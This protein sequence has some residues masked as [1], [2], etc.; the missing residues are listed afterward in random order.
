MSKTILQ[1]AAAMAGALATLPLAACGDD[2]DARE[3]E[4]AP[5]AAGRMPEATVRLGF[6]STNLPLEAA[7]SRGFFDEENLTVTTTQV[8]TSIDM[9][10][11][12]AAGTMDIAMTSADNPVNYRLNV[13]NPVN[14]GG[15]P[16]DVQM[17]FGDHLGLG[18]ALVSQPDL[19]TFESLR[20]KT[21]GVDAPV[22][23]FAFVL[24]QMLLDNGLERDADYAVTQA[25]GTP[26]R[27]AAMRAGEI[28][29]TLLNADSIVRAREEGFNV[30]ATIDDVAVPYLGGTG[31]AHQTWLKDNSDVA[32]RFIRAYIRGEL[33]IE[34]PDNRQAVIDLITDEETPAA[35]AEKIYEA[36]VDDP[37]GIISKAAFDVEGLFNVIA[38]RE[39]WDGLEQRQDLES[40]AS[41]MSGLFELKY[42]DKAVRDVER[43]DR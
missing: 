39:A 22:S 35:L 20:G 21:C 1:I 40:L 41:P 14:N 24:Y 31:A 4:G 3:P 28:D 16:L 26:I 25:G 7:F 42:Y 27:L 23:G 32:I 15:E 2:L 10:Q 30:L 5:T 19:T 43:E 17:I 29:C 12:V 11:S 18:L 34:D 37:T 13:D 36:A 33:W 9:F 6:F 38:L 8:T